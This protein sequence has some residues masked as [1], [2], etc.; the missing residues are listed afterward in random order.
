MSVSGSLSVGGVALVTAPD[1][2]SISVVSGYEAG[3]RGLVSLGESQTPEYAV[4]NGVVKLRGAIAKSS[5]NMGE[6]EVM[7][8]AAG[9]V[10]SAGAE[11]RYFIVASS[12]QH[13]A[14]KDFA[15]VRIGSNGAIYANMPKHANYLYLDTISY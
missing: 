5:A 6:S 9:A 1:W 2:I 15:H 11:S 12:S 8:T 13:A 7:L 4:L 14:G 10:P 3:E